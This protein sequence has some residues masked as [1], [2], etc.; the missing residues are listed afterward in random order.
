MKTISY[1]SKVINKSNDVKTPPQPLKRCAKMGGLK[2]FRNRTKK[3]KQ[4]KI[5]KDGKKGRKNK[6]AIGYAGGGVR[7]T[8]KCSKCD[9]G[10][11]DSVRDVQTWVTR[12]A[13]VCPEFAEFINQDVIKDR[14]SSPIKY[15]HKGK[16]SDKNDWAYTGPLFLS[17]TLDVENMPESIPAPRR[18]GPVTRSI[19]DSSSSTSTGSSFG[20]RKAEDKND[21]EKKR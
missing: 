6:N 4:Y 18:P 1:V 12:H 15:N 17:N 11:T 10:K 5:I 8:I 7:R 2:T 21:N 16:T 3:P 19:S 14:L 9:K 20:K 13:S